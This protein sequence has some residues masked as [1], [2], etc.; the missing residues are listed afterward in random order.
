MFEGRIRRIGRRFPAVI[1]VGRLVRSPRH[2]SAVWRDYLRT[3]REMAFLR[4]HRVPAGAKRVAVFVLTENVYTLKLQLALASGLRLQGWSAVVLVGGPH[5][6]WVKR[7]ARAVGIS[8]FARYDQFAPG[9]DELAGC[10]A[11]A[12]IL[13]DRMEGFQQVKQWSYRGCSIGPQLLSTVSR[14][15]KRGAPDPR[16][17]VIRRELA[18]LVPDTLEHVHRAEHAV[19]ALRADL[20][21]VVEANYATYGVLVDVAVQAGVPVIQVT[22]PWRDDALMCRRLVPATRREHPSSLS[23]ASMRRLAAERPW[24]AVEE[25]ELEREFADRYGGRWFLQ[26]R[27]QP[28]T[29]DLDEVGLR[30]RLG[31]DAGRKLAV[32]FSHIL[33]DAN[34]FYGEDLFNDYG[35]WFVE[36][37]RAA[38]AND[39][40]DWLV[41]LHPANL[42]K[43]AYE[44]F[45]GE[46]A[47]V[48]ILRERLGELPR[49]V[50]LLSADTDISSL[51][52]YRIADYGVTVRGT[53]GMEMA[54]FGKP[55]LTA[56]TGRY[57][58]LGFTIDSATSEE[59]LERLSR[60]QDL[61]KLDERTTQ[62]ARRH[63]HAVFRLRPWVMRS[64][65]S[66]FRYRR[67]GSHPLD[68]NLRPQVG[69]V[70]ELR[71]NGDLEAWATWAAGDEVD[72]LDG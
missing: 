5:L 49:H 52:L 24:T 64:F 29:R 9:A 41:K 12:K 59:Y 3:R 54:C 37:V 60:L 20:G 6:R 43:R 10:R 62:M 21:L 63:A 70:A 26:A 33:W 58:G 55:V 14:S 18:G 28:G 65:R 25:A 13:L 34:L 50:R 66:D 1:D 8:E 46:Y 45:H 38:C 32:V 7:Y 56:G 36:T 42:W 47:E 57:S 51:S 15:E 35:E 30:Q 31:L 17:P 67:S 22:Q 48:A 11:H 2:E 68:H 72:F 40:L 16:D 39:G 4:E 23:P 19:S 61:G 69:S 27:N 71:Q 53:P 44:R